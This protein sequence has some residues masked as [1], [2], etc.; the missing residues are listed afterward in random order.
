[1]WPFYS[2]LVY[3]VY[4]YESLTPESVDLKR[5]TYFG[6]L[7]AQFSALYGKLEFYG[8]LLDY[9]FY[10]TAGAGL[11]TTEQTCIPNKDGC[12]DRIDGLGFGL[13]N[14]EDG[15]DHLKI[16]AHLGGG[17]RFFFSDVV[18]LRF[19]V[20]DVAYADRDVQPGTVT[21]DIRN[22]ILFFLGLSVLL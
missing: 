9:D 16:A 22:T 6:A 21:T 10:A 7:S 5:M 15:A 14:P 11:S 12:G 8:F 2:A 1:M 18:G 17:M 20:R 19:E 13:K 4:E 3:E